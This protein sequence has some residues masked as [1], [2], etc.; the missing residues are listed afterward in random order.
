MTERGGKRCRVAVDAPGGPL[1]IELD[2]PAAANIAE[3]LAQARRLLQHPATPATGADAAIDWD[4]GATGIWGQRRE[5]TAV[6]R[7]GDRV[8]LYRALAADPRQQRRTRARK[9]AR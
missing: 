4:A 9:A 2:L 6:P 5:R 7:D 1:L 3:A 8:E